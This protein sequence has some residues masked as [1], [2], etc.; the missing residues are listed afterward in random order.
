M[1]RKRSLK[2]TLAIAL[3]VTGCSSVVN[4]TP[5]FEDIKK[6]FNVQFQE[7]RGWQSDY[8][9]NILQ[10]TAPE[11]DLTISIVSVDN[12]KSSEDA[13]LMAWRKLDAKFN[14]KVIANVANLQHGGWDEIREIELSSENSDL[15]N[16]STTVF[17]DDDQWRVLLIDGSAATLAKQSA[18]VDSVIDSFEVLGYQAQDFSIRKPN[19][20]SEKSIFELNEFI[21]TAMQR[22]KVPGVGLA[23][24]QNGKVIFEGGLGVADIQSQDPVTSQTR[25][26][27]A[28]NTKGLTTLLLSKMVELQKVKWDDPVILH[29]PQFRLGDEQTTKSVLIKHLVCACT[30]LPRK[31]L[32]WA[33]NDGPKTPAKSVFDE[34]ANTMPTSG[35]GEIY[36]YNNQMAAAAGYIAG[37][38][39]YPELEPG[40]AYDKALKTYILQP[41]GMNSS[42]F[43]PELAMQE[44]YYAKAYA[45]DLYGQVQ[46]VEQST[47]RGFNLTI[48]PHRPAGA[49]WSTVSDMIHYIQIELSAGISLDGTRVFEPDTVLK[50]REKQVKSGTN[51]TY[52][53]GLAVEQVNGIEIVT[54]GGSMVGYK[55]NFYAIPSANVGVVV[56]TNSDEGYFIEKLLKQKLLEL[57]Y[58]AEP[59]SNKMLDVFVEKVSMYAS[60]Y[61]DELTIPADPT[62]LAM[63][64]PSY[65]SDELGDISIIRNKD[66]I[67]LDTGLWKSE[68]ATKQSDDATFI[69]ATTTPGVIGLEFTLG[70]ENGKKTLTVEEGQHQYVFYER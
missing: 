46:P 33:F 2:L 9:N 32:N 21:K 36:Q 1:V 28:S 44:G 24:L 69:I 51:E 68:L 3:V 6:S 38:I 65:Y 57:T 31:D 20:L 25:F 61:K 29:Y 49:L 63:L 7:L 11:N 27:I 56:L 4:Q 54:H 45:L 8:K 39:A 67:F 26:M 19:I 59:L 41:L 16:L 35:F 15:I 10:Y 53:M 18:A 34:L 48:I 23:V 37:H 52:G 50:R 22:L 42:T 40:E 60:L 17:Y 5:S 14:G 12:A 43:L 64:A 62:I 13:A 58:D 47:T 66:G 55:S 30:G 70:E